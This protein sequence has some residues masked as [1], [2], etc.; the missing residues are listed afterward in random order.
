MSDILITAEAS[1][2]SRIITPSTDLCY[3]LEKKKTTFKEKI[4]ES[5]SE[6]ADE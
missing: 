3:S 5:V 1:D 4:K 6:K 2:G